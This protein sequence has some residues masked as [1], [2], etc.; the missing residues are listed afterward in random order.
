M[1]KIKTKYSLQEIAA[2]RGGICLDDNY[3]NVHQKVEWQCHNG[4]KWTALIK[5]ILYNNSWCPHC[6]I[7]IGENICKSYLESIFQRSFEKCRPTWLVNENGNLLELDGY[8]KSLGIAFEYNGEQHYSNNN[9]W[10]N[11]LLVRQ[12][13]DDLK[14]KLCKEND[15]KLIVIPQLFTRLKLKNLKKYLKQECTKEGIELPANYDDLEIDLNN[16]LERPAFV[17]YKNIA[18][19]KGGKC[20]SQNYINCTT[21]LTW[22]CHLGHIWEAQPYSIKNGSWCPHC[23]KTAV[24]RF[25]DVK[26]IIEDKNGIM[27]DNIY[28]NC[29]TKISVKCNVCLHIWKVSL[30]KIKAGRWC[31]KCANKKRTGRKKNKE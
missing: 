18:K 25:E 26:K 6:K 15:V 2:A 14:K 9:P 30:N 22:Q 17:E 13:W 4:H 1:T 20:L 29:A 23:A 31:P 28:V 5:N 3:Q 11:N 16:I 7:S 10:G 21:K 27:L 19:S 12:S 8:C 24:P